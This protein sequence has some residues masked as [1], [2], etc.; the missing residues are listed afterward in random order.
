[1]SERLQESFVFLTSAMSAARLTDILEQV[2]LNVW[3][4]SDQGG[5]WGGCKDVEHAWEPPK[6]SPS[7]AVSAVSGHRGREFLKP[8]VRDRRYSQQHLVLF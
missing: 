7:P 5:P 2:S 8:A 6:K 4:R 3:F 1:M